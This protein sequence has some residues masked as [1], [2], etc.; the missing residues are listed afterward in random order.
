[1]IRAVTL[2]IWN[3][4]GPW[5]ERLPLIIKALRA[6][7]ADLVGLQEVLRFET[8]DQARAI[9][10]GAGFEHLA[11]G[12]AWEI[13]GGLTFGNA[14]LSRQPLEDVRVEPLPVEPGG[15][16]RSLLLARAG[17]V[18]V[19]VTHLTW[20]LHLADVRAQQVRRID[21]LAREWA[22]SDGFP[23]ILMGDFNAEPE[24]D[25][26][27]FLCG[28]GALGGRGTYWADCF[29][30]RGDGPGHTYARSN[31]YAFATREPSRRIDY[32]FVRGPDRKLRGEPISARIVFDQGAGG[33]FP[34]DHYGVYAE[35]TD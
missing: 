27:R 3:R 7:D 2:N 18:P 33:V 6:L 34:S 32:V 25:E 26:I 5:D 20:Q 16:G 17:E 12:P 8:Q 31:P 21:D 9:A 24:S 23:P 13:G 4:Q 11:Y 14:I 35:I 1:M 28:R 22:P 15:Q 30:L 10:A 19:L 29:G